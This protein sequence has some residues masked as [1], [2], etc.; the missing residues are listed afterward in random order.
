MSRTLLSGNEAV[1]QGDGA[2]PFLVTSLLNYAMPFIRYRNEDCGELVNDV[3]SCGNNFP[4]TE[5][6]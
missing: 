1:A 5:R 2:R 4:L 3:C 6:P